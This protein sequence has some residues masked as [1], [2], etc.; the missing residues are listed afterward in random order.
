MLT[1]NT[2]MLTELRVLFQSVIQRK[3]FFCAIT[4]AYAKKNVISM[5]QFFLEGHLKLGHNE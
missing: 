1:R 5:L 4:D 3:D 2:Y